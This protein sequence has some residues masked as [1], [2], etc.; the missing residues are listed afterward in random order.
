W[1]FL[2]NADYNSRVGFPDH[3][4]LSASISL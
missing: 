3:A 1:E 2:K 4:I